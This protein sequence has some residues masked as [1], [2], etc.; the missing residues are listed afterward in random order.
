MQAGVYT[1]T[2]A[3]DGKIYVG[4]SSNIVARWA[5]HRNALKLKKHHCRHL[6][7]AWSRDGQEAFEFEIVELVDDPLFIEAREQFW[8]WRLDVAN[9]A[10]GYNTAPA[11][12]S[13]LGHPMPREVRQKISRIK[14]GRPLTAEHRAA[15]KKAWAGNEERR[16]QGKQLIRY[17]LANAHTLEWRSSVSKAMRGRTLSIEHRM[18]VSAASLGRAKSAL[19]VERVR[20][21]LTGRTL[22]PEHRA[23]IS[24]GLRRRRQTISRVHNRPR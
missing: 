22:S 5:K 17:A 7:Y 8:M 10:R 3:H 19:A 2:N 6:Q 1:I 9:S 16:R 21:A 11:A 15:L 20:Q 12:G 13:M 23:A 24:A 18:K 4:S 14:T